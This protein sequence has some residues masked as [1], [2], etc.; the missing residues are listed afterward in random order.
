MPPDDPTDP[1][2]RP[3]PPTIPRARPRWPGGDAAPLAHAR[4]V[5]SADSAPSH[6]DAGP[7]SLSELGRGARYVR[8]AVIGAGGMGE[9]RLDRDRRIGRE[10][11]VKRLHAALGGR[12]DTQARFLREARVQGQLE[13]PAIVP[14]YDLGAGEDGELYFT[15]KRVRGRTLADILADLAHGDAEAKK[16]FGRRRLLSA[17]SQ[18]CL[19]IDYAHARGVMHRDLKPGNVMLGDWGEVYV[20]DWGSRR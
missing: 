5:A 9:V 10:V 16:R 20:L 1:L 6:V 4:T 13:H 7:V 2:P 12:E 3:W 8:G 19:A 11:A 15:M 14:V 18:V 17:F